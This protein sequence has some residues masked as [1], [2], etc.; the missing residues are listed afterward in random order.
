M[1]SCQHADPHQANIRVRVMIWPFTVW[2]Q[3]QCMPRFCHG[4]YVRYWHI[5]LAHRVNPWFASNTFEENNNYN[6]K[7]TLKK[8][9]KLKLE[10]KTTVMLPYNSVILCS[11]QFVWFP[12]LSLFPFPSFLTRCVRTRLNGFIIHHQQCQFSLNQA[13]SNIL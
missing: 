1:Q 12:F 4:L 9:L 2:P 13:Q 10:K 3:G 6:N 8:F 7:F 11:F 5:L